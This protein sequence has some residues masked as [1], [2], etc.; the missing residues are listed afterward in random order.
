MKRISMILAAVALVLGLSQCKKQEQ[1]A[2]NE[3]GTVAITLDV[4]AHDGS[5]IN[6]NPNNGMVAFEY[7]DVVYVASG[8]KFV[9]TLTNNGNTFAGN[10]TNPTEGEPLY[11]FF[12]GN[13]TPEETLTPGSS[14]SCSV[15]I[16][17]QTSGYPVISFATS[18]ETFTGA[19]LYTAFFLNKAALVKF[20]V[21]TLSSN[22]TCILGLNNKV[23]VDF[24][25]NGFA[26]SQ[27]DNGLV[28]LSGWSGEHWAILLPQTALAEGDEGTVYTEDGNYWGTR[29][30]IPAITA[31]DYLNEGIALA[32]TVETNPGTTPTGAVS[33]KF[34]INGNGDRVYFSQGNL[35]YKANTGI[36]QFA[37][38]QYNYI[39]DANGSI[40]ETYDGWIDLFGWGTSGYNHG[41]NCYQPWST[42]T[43]YGD[44]YAY[45]EYTYNLYD[46]TGKA[47][48]GYNAISNGGNTEGQWR[49]LTNDE[50]YYVFY[51]RPTLS[52]I[53]YAKATVDGVNG[54][55]LLPNDWDASSYDLNN[56]NS[57]GANFTSNTIT[58]TDWANTLE[59]NG[60]VFLPAAGYR[61]GTSVYYVGSSGG[62]WSSSSGDSYDAY[63][64]Y[65]RSGYL[66]TNNGSRDRGF[67]VRLVRSCQ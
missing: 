7:G 42:S 22:P 67:S 23:T 4:K 35:Q 21:T 18:N 1:S 60:A 37:S 57:S 12:L 53:R 14:T 55:I 20:D 29:P 28:K 31:N 51:S 50:W 64:L 65:F 11:F 39:G 40:S 6:V 2:S 34:T 15:N 52:G 13:K 17:D 46:Q 38:N 36:W 41:A 56:T 27:V 58:A 43:N 45:G 16:S 61:Y 3:D 24:S 33:G 66:N 30:A 62:Y 32:A 26:Y 19:G 9:G 63:Y 44:Y 48:W 54:V 59:A 5:R 49:T 25:T 10:I 8:Q 47:D